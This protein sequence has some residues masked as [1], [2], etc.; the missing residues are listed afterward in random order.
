MS[1]RKKYYIYAQSPIDYWL[2]W[3]T[4]MEYIK[5]V[6]NLYEEEKDDPDFHINDF[7]CRLVEIAGCFKKAGWE[8]DISGQDL[9]VT[10][11]PNGN[12]EMKIMVGLKQDNNG[13]TFIA[14]PYPLPWMEGESSHLLYN[15]PSPYRS[16][17]FF[18]SQR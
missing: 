2:R 18:G 11:L 7:I 1:D 9:Y 4:P 6:R 16:L 13:M 12:F 8:G 15:R 10:E 3:K 17:G 14:S 5:S